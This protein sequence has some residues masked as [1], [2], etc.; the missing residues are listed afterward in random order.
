[1]SPQRAPAP[2]R[3]ITVVA[4][5]ACVALAAVMAV[6]LTGRRGGA[7][8]RAEAPRPPDSREV[9]L[10][11]R[12]RHREYRDGRPAVDVRGER[13]YRGPDG[14][15]HLAGSVEV[16]SLGPEGATVARL[17]AEEVVYDPGSLLFTFTGDVRIEAGGVALEGGCF[18]YDKPRGLFE[19]T[20][21]GRFSS[22]T[23]AGSAPEIAYLEGPDEVR[24]GGGF[25]AALTG[26]GG[27][28]SGLTVSGDS[29]VYARKERRGRVQ[30][31]AGLSTGP[32]RGTA[33]AVAFTVDPDETAL[34]SAV[35]EGAARLTL[36]RGR[37][38]GPAESGI[39][40]AR[41]AVAFPGLSAESWPVDAEGDVVLILTAQAGRTIKIVTPAASLRLDREGGPLSWSASGGVAA[42]IDA[43]SGPGFALAGGAASFEASSGVV[44]VE[45]EPGRPAA[46]DSADVRVEAD[47]IVIGPGPEDLGASG[48][49]ECL[50]KPG[51][52]ASP[53]AGLF[54]ATESVTVRCDSMAWPGG[55]SETMFSGGVLARQGARV[56]RAGE[57]FLARRSGDLRGRGG[58]AVEMDQGGAGDPAGRRIELGGRDMVYR[59]ERGALSLSDGAFVRLPEARL[60]AE[61][62]SAVIDREQ[63]GVESLEGRKGVSVSKGAYKGRSEKASYEAATRTLTLT[64]R[65][66]LTD[67]QG[68]SAKGA[69][70]TFDLADDKIL[71]E[72]EGPGRATTVI[73]S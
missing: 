58:V 26:A 71:I 68:G 51:G 61:T 10:K 67:G 1:M 24:L 7:V 72:N 27:T 54:S 19:T 40:A 59:S 63:A 2:V 6:L 17:T 66:V 31:R 64:G 15:N 5:V 50:L 44:R 9:D 53:A 69:K 34:E 41:I 11:E 12:V 33:A 45:R 57:L 28:G 65:P 48:G 42:E 49:V 39:A 25:Q 4:A 52:D 30:G 46:A 8:R 22:R 14:R 73:R 43:A 70:L 32:C 20:G 35:F 47:E 60:E 16:A 23:I 21:G 13:F 36:G 18:S 3:L 56:L 29:L 55:G 38:T 37:P 62:L